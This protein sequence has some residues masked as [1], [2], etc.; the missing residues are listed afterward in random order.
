[1]HVSHDNPDP[2]SLDYGLTPYSTLTSQSLSK[3]PSY[4]FD[5]NFSIYV[6]PIKRLVV[7]NQLKTVVMFKKML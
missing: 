7:R 2:T 5:Y 6:K 3:K 1:M 4:C